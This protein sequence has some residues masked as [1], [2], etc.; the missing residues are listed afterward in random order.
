MPRPSLYCRFDHQNNYLFIDVYLSPLQGEVRRGGG[1]SYSHEFLTWTLYYDGWLEAWVILPPQINLRYPRR[2]PTAVWTGY[3]NW[4]TVPR[5]F[6]SWPSH[7]SHCD[8][9]TSVS[10]FHVDDKLRAGAVLQVSTSSPHL[11]RETGR[12]QPQSRSSLQ[13]SYV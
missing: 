12:V 9:P 6:S 5:S 3:R 10:L 1:C 8:N 7:C 11:G 13:E 4:T 2:V